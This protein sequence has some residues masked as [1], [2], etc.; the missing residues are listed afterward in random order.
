MII[1]VLSLWEPWASAMRDGLK[2]IETRPWYMSYRGPLGIHHAKKKFNSEEWDP[3]FVQQLFR[4]GLLAHLAYGQ[5]T[6]IV[7]VYG[8]LK[9][10]A[11]RDK[12]TPRELMY[13]NYADKDEDTG[14]QRYAIK[15]RNRRVLPRPMQMLGHQGLFDWEVP[16]ELEH[17]IPNRADEPFALEMPS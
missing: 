2:E 4:D 1:K 10:G 8:C 13:G 3:R 12:I 16:P 17:L 7:D 6:T 14:K 15:T 9:T 5:L 11:V